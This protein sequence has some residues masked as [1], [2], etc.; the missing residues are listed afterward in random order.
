MANPLLT[1]NVDNT[2][3]VNVVAQTVCNRIDILED[4]NLGTSNLLVQQP[5]NSG[6]PGTVRAP[7]QF[8]FYPPAGKMFFSPGDVV[9]NVRVVPGGG[10]MTLQQRESL[11]QSEVKATS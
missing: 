1:F 10:A 6:T 11:M 9:G 8:T 3:Y 2:A 5:A 4:A 7:I